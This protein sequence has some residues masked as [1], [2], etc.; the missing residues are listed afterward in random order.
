VLR[1]PAGWR[2]IRFF[3]HV[4]IT[5]PEGS[6]VLM[7]F[8]SGAP[9]L[10]EQD[11]GEGRVLT[12][13]S[14]LARDW[15]D[16]AIHPLFVRF[17]AE[18]TAYLAGAHAESFTALVG[19]ATEA[20]A[21]ARGG[22]QVFDPSGKRALL[23]QGTSDTTRFV[24]EMPGYYEIRG[25]GRSD[26]IA[27]NPDPRESALQRLPEESVQRWLGLQREA[28]SPGSAGSGSATAASGPQPWLPV[29]FWLLLAAGLLAFLEPVVA[30]YH[31]HILR[32]RSE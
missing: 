10:L 19:S 27:V 28:A 14:P 22:G 29:W 24:P 26:Y 13:T 25:G 17:V 31:L 32:E 9:L 6:N 11:L 4:P 1:D 30:N 18:A 5:E 20:V 12:L 7:R 23:L 3:R 16:L 21:G 8:D 15:N 2:S